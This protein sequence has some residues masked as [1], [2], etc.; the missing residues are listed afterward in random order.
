MRRWG[1][2]GGRASHGGGWLRRT[3]SV[4]MKE[5]PGRIYRGRKLPGHMGHV[6]RTVQNLQVVEVR[7]EE[8][9]LMVQGSVPGP[10]GAIVIIRNACKKQNGAPKS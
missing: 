4:G 2:A 5:H 7:P 9:L 10:N 8:N 1:F 6:R 3:G